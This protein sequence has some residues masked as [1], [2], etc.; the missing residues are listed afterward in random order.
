[1]SIIHINEVRVNLKTFTGSSVEIA[2][3]PFTNII[4]EP[5]SQSNQTDLLMM[6]CHT[7]SK[8]FDNITYKDLARIK[9]KFRIN[10]EQAAIYQIIE[11]INFYTYI[12]IFTEG[13]DRAGIEFL[14]RMVPFFNLLTNGYWLSKGNISLFILKLVTASGK[15]GL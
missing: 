11:K 6:N 4:Y 7:K 15:G 10:Y 2:D 1:M 14:I 8:Q 3:E 12:I 5:V 9:V 13:F